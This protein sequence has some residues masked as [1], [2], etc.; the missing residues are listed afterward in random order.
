MAIEF[1]PLADEVGNL[2]DWFTVGVGAIGAIATT[3][4]AFLAYRTSAR[5]TDIAE[6]AKGIAEQQHQEAV[7]VREES[8]RVLG[9]LLLTEVASLPE[10]VGS[11]LRMLNQALVIDAEPRA[12]DRRTFEAALGEARTDLMP[13][14]E[15]CQERIHNFPDVLGADLATLIGTC[16]SLNMVARKVELR[17]RWSTAIAAAGL[18]PFLY[19]GNRQDLSILLRNVADLLEMSIAFAADFRQF[20][21]VDPYDYGE[22]SAEALAVITEHQQTN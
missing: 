20:V 12:T 8:A 5:A 22:L 11:I 1:C 7:R 6:E 18:S 13:F 3:A 21:G 19:D 15:K 9:R 2:A 14:S 17:T 16:Q 4:V 10:R